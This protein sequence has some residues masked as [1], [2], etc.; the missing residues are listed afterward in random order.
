M[1]AALYSRL[2]SIA[3]RWN[4]TAPQSARRRLSGHLLVESI[5]QSRSHPAAAFFPLEQDQD[6]PLSGGLVVVRWL[7]GGGS[8]L[9]NAGARSRV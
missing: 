7:S 3:V 9:A 2:P 1:R 8:Q 5:E 6:A 4:L